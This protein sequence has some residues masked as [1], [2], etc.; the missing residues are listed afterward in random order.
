MSF[1]GRCLDMPGYLMMELPLSL[2]LALISQ[3]MLIMIIILWFN[4]AVI[5][6]LYPLHVLTWNV[7]MPVF[8]GRPVL[9]KT[10]NH[11]TIETLNC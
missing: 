5:G 6:G 4:I 2:M 11:P 1:H 9:L 10:Q 7:M 8:I 3:S